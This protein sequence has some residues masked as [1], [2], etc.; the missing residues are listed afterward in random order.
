MSPQILMRESLAYPGEREA[1]LKAGF[2]IHTSRCAVDPGL[3]IGRYSV[4]PNY[5]EL[6]HDLTYRKAILPHDYV[7][8]SWV[9]AFSWVTDPLIATL[10]P[11]TWFGNDFAYS[12]DPGPF[13]VRGAT[14]SRKGS[15]F[16][17]MF[18][19]DR[20]AALE[21]ANRL[22]DDEEIARQG[23]VYRKYVPLRAFGHDEVT[24]IPLANE[25]RVFC[26]MGR[27]LTHAP[28]WGSGHETWAP[29]AMVVVRKVLE[30]DIAKAMF[31]V[32]DVA[33]T[34]A[35]DWIVVEL[36][37]GQMSGLQETDPHE[38]YRQLHSAVLRSPTA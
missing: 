26:W 1:A 32:I 20:R 14:N 36:N 12:S 8:H 4:L 18:A 24:G 6:T 28:Y 23:L 5:H 19:P 7:L 16:R 30:V 2:T 3:V 37:D 34:E 25:W 11:E 13:V 33:E 10:T 21:V 15:W 17:R 31:L 38:F 27:V 29:E 9:A 22:L 35:G